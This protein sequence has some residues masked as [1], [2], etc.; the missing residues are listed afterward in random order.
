[1]YRST[2]RPTDGWTDV[3]ADFS[4]LLTRC[5]L[6]KIPRTY[7][8]QVRVTLEHSVKCFRRRRQR[9][10]SRRATIFRKRRTLPSGRECL[11][12]PCARYIFLCSD[13]APLSSAPLLLYLLFLSLSLPP[14]S[15]PFFSFLARSMRPSVR[16][17]RLVYLLAFLSSTIP[18]YP[19]HFS[20][21]RRFSP[22]CFVRSNARSFFVPMIL[23]RG[24]IDQ[25]HRPTSLPCA[26]TI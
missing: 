23:R 8:R 22:S 20:L 17:A 7:L 2:D 21:P 16:R 24:W 4:S 3:L 12:T 14:P 19:L 18:F 15:A 26:T 10:A 1:V 9:R 13:S 25:R 6:L 5:P 11:S